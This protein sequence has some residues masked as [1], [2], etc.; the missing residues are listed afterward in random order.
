MSGIFLPDMNIEIRKLE[1]TDAHKLSELVDLYEDVFEMEKFKKPS[2][3]YFEKMLSESSVIVFIAEK[4]GKIIGGMTAHILHSTYFESAYVYVYDLA[5]K[6]EFQRQGVGTKLMEKIKDYSRKLG[7][8]EV[9]LQA[10][11]VD[12]YAVDFYT[13]IG[14]LPEDDV[15]HF[16]FP[17]NKN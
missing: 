11:K 10:D 14:G 2:L 13:K 17:L 8:D 9:F 4:D 1:S 6:G 5:V 3:D 16:A 15:I 7:F 12:K